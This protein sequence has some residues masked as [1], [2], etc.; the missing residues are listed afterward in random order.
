MDSEGMGLWNHKISTI[1]ISRISKLCRIT[2]NLEIRNREEIGSK[3][4]DVDDHF[5][6]QISELQDDTKGFQPR[7]SCDD[8]GFPNK[9]I[10]VEDDFI[11]QLSTIQD[12]TTFTEEITASRS[13][14]MDIAGM[15][16]R[17]FLVEKDR[18]DD[19]IMDIANLM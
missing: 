3:Q 17:E 7:M 6:Q 15:M 8:H 13:A 18:E 19:G 1:L 5:L 12:V 9:D 10:E 16:D 14:D 4:I 11:N 2:M